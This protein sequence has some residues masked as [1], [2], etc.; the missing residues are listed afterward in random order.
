[1]IKC[2]EYVGLSIIRRCNLPRHQHGSLE[3][4]G[5]LKTSEVCHSKADVLAIPETRQTAL[6]RNGDK[7]DLVRQ[8][9]KSDLY[10]KELG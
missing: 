9:G 10:R 1:M 6:S 3:G 4:V 5:G 8:W 7:F 2:P